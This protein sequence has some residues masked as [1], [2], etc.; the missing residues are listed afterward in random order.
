[1]AARLT[2]FVVAAIVAITFVA[3]LIVGAQREDESG[4][5]DLI[6]YNGRIYVA[7]AGF[8]SVGIPDCVA[9]ARRIAAAITGTAH[10]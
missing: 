10:G 3:G 9:D 2:A 1:M 6:V 8:R 5:I 7:G 4:P